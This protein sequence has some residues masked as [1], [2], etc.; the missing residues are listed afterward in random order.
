[1]QARPF[2]TDCG[3]FDHV[4]PSRREFLYVGAI[5]GLG[6]TLPEYLLRLARADQKSYEI[7]SAVA[8]SV[9][10]IFLPGGISARESFDPKPD[11]PIEYRGPFAAIDANVVGV[12][13]GQHLVE[14]AKIADRLTLCRSMTHGEAAHER[15]THNLFTGYRPSPAVQYPSIGAVVSHELGPRGDLPPYVCVPGVPNVYAGTGYLSTRYGPFSLGAAPED[16]GFAVRDLSLPAD[17]DAARHARRRRMLDAVDEHFRS[18]EKSDALAAMDDFYQRAYSM[19]SSRSA[20]E[21]FHLDAEPAELRDAYGRNAAGQ[22]MLLCRRLAE[23]GVRFVSMVYGGWDHHSNIAGGMPGQLAEFD[24]AF[25]TLIRDLEQRGMLDSTL[26]MVTSE[27]GRTPKIN[28][29][30]GRDHWPRVFS[31]VLAGGGVKRGSVY[32]AS[33]ATG[34]EP[35]H[36]PLSVEDLATTIYNQ[37]G[38]VADKELL[39]PGGRPIEIVKGG[40]VVR[41][42]LDKPA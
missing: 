19:I 14:T 41:A 20:R 5:A 29:D 34:S 39:A 24:R 23:A 15:G 2:C 26:V 32:G 42:L 3:G 30:G 16:A 11:A 37:L 28:R 17:V 40:S 18:L 8:Q 6:L 25:A 36:H 13:L 10:H 35:A 33:D 7:K 22:R 38:I 9:I 4:R 27:F 31:V 21:A 1:M 12:R